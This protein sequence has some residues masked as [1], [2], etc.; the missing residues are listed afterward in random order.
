MTPI[1]EIESV[2]KKF[3]VS[4]N[5]VRYKT[6]RE[7]LTSFPSLKAKREFWA[8]RDIS[9][10]MN[11]GETM[12]IIGENGAGKT[13]LLKILSKITRPTTGRGKIHGRVSS[14]LEVGTGFHPELTGKENIYL[15]GVILGL[16]KKEIDINFEKIVEFAGVNNFLN[17]PVKHYSTGMWARLAFSVAAHLEPEIL[18]IDEVLSVG[19]AEFQKKSL[20]KMNELSSHGRT[21]VFVSHNMAAVRNLCNRCMLISEGKIRKIGE[22]NEVIDAYLSVNNR[23]ND[24]TID[25]SNYPKR[26]GSQKVKLKKIELRNQDNMITGTFRIKDDLCIHLF[27][28]SFEYIRNVKIVVEILEASGERICSMYDSDSGFSLKNVLGNTHVSIAVK[29]I[30]FCPGRYH[31]SV[32]LVSEIF[33]YQ[34]D[35]YD[36]IE[37]AISFDVENRL[38]E[39]NLTRRAGLLFLTPQ[40]QIYQ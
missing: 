26:K 19:D 15:N 35:Y 8:L 9:F 23:H 6:L 21:V 25:L 30:R 32:S 10:S 27:F 5:T 4:Q 28:E 1:I 39:R 34:L 2:S 33:N 7:S 31:I 20:A 16:K 38:I 24:G 18:L 36:E 13:T 11:P 14:L 40:W 12:G 22:V 3:L 29:D 37:Y 17:T